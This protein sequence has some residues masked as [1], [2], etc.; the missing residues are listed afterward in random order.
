MTN[1]ASAK[2][3]PQTAL[4]SRTRVDMA[5]AVFRNSRVPTLDLAESFSNTCRNKWDLMSETHGYA[6]WVVLKSMGPIG[7]R[8]YYSP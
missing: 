8:L 2:K 3:A 1:R 6:K 4:E 7:Y 5:T